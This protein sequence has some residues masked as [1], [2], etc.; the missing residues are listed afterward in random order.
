MIE[1]MTQLFKTELNFLS[2]FCNS[3]KVHSARALRNIAFAHNYEKAANVE[4][5]WGYGF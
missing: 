1:L 4:A 2:T 5:F 3:E